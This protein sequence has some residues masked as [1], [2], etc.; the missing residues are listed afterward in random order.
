MQ[1]IE[2]LKI[3][4]IIAFEIETARPVVPFCYLFLRNSKRTLLCVLQ[5]RLFFVI[6]GIIHAHKAE[7]RRRLPSGLGGECLN[8]DSQCTHRTTF[9]GKF[10]ETKQEHRHGGDH[11]PQQ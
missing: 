9:S 2:S 4:G 7:T 8:L 5:G 6:T 3:R 10:T 11:A 1:M